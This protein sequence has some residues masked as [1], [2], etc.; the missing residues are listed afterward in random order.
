MMPAA[1]VEPLIF[2]MLSITGRR[3]R[4]AL[5]EADSHPEL[6]AQ[7]LSLMLN[8]VKDKSPE[9]VL[10]AIVI[11]YAYERF[12]AGATGEAPSHQHSVHHQAAIRL[13]RQCSHKNEVKEYVSPVLKWCKG[14]L[15]YLKRMG[16]NDEVCVP[17]MFQSSNQ[18]RE[19]FLK[20]LQLDR[21]L[22]R[23][24]MEMWSKST[25]RYYETVR[26]KDWG[27]SRHI[28]T[29]MSEY[30]TIHTALE[31]GIAAEQK[32]DMLGILPQD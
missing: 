24:P 6:Y 30:S 2:D 26:G 18:A 13:F 19:C 22:A 32:E 7:I 8:I 12:H 25:L 10:V 14:V 4:F 11:I 5:S 15:S 29:L 20:I 9:M 27:V 1:Y 21:S 28:L 16:L 17:F 31:L 23:R 3:H